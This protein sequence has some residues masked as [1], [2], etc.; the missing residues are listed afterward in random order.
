M[1]AASVSTICM[2]HKCL[3]KFLQFWFATGINCCL[4][5]SHQLRLQVIEWF[6]GIDL[7]P[8]LVLEMFEYFHHFLLEFGH[9]IA[10]KWNNKNWKNST[11]LHANDQH[12]PFITE[13]AASWY[14]QSGHIQHQHQIRF[15]QATFGIFAPIKIQSFGCAERNA[16]KRIPI[17][18]QCYA[19]A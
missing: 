1:A 11:C 7:F 6:I 8:T 5:M 18:N 4:H 15:E 10:V 14:S 17:D 13:S 16:R 12:L 2:R 19:I 9:F 3:P